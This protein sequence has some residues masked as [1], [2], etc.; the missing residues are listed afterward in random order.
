[1]RKLRSVTFAVLLTVFGTS[2]CKNSVADQNNNSP[3]SPTQQKGPKITKVAKDPGDATG[4]KLVITGTGFGAAQG[5]GKLTFNG[6]EVSAA[7]WGENK[8]TASVPPTI[9][10]DKI[11]II[12]RVASNKSYTYNFSSKAPA[13]PKPSCSQGPLELEL[14]A[15]GDSQGLANLLN[16]LFRDVKVDPGSAAGAGTSSKADGSLCVKDRATGRYLSKCNPGAGAGSTDAA[17]CQIQKIVTKV[18]IDAFKGN[19]LTSNFIVHLPILDTVPSPP[20]SIAKGLKGYFVRPAPNLEI[21]ELVQDYFL[22]A[23]ASGAAEQAAKIGEDLSAQ[24]GLVKRDLEQLDHLYGDAVSDSDLRQS[25]LCDMN[26]GCPAGRAQVADKAPFDAERW[27]AKHTVRLS[28]LKP[29]D[30]ALALQDLSMWTFQ[31]R[32]FGDALSILPAELSAPVSN[33][34]YFSADV[35]ERDMLY[36]QKQDEEK[37]TSSPKSTDTGGK[38]STPAPATTTTQ[39][40]TTLETISGGKATAPAL[41]TKVTT[42]TTTPASNPPPSSAP[43]CATAP[44]KPSTS[45]SD[46]TTGSSTVNATSAQSAGTDSSTKAADSSTNPG[47]GGTKGGGSTPPAAPAAPSQQPFRLD[48]VVRL[49]HLRQ[50][51]KIVAAI[52]AAASS[53]DKPLVQAVDDNGNNDLIL[54][55]PT[56]AGGADQTSSIR[57]AISMFDLPRPQLSLQVWSYQMSAQKKPLN[58][59]NENHAAQG[60]EVISTGLQET[61]NASND[62][63]MGALEAGYGTLLNLANN[64]AYF[65]QRFKNYLTQRFSN[66]ISENSYCL[67]YYDALDTSGAGGPAA[68]ASLNRLLLYLI[69]ASDAQ[70]PSAARRIICSMNNNVGNELC[71]AADEILQGA[72]CQQLNGTSQLNFTHFCEQLIKLGNPRNLHIFQAALLDFL[73]Q[74]RWTVVYP[75]DFV[76]YDLQRTAHQLDSLFGPIVDAFNQD[77]DRYI[78]GSLKRFTDEIAPT[79]S[80]KKTG[81]ISA[82]SVQVS[83]LSGTQATVDGKVNNYFD[84]TP[85]LS[86]NDI[87]NTGNQ[88]NLASNLKNILEPKEILILQSLANIGNQPRIT[89]EIS[90]EAKL[91]ITPTTLD[92]ASSALLDVDFDVSEPNGP[93]TVNQQNS[94]KDLLDR[95]AEHHVVTHVRVESLKLFQL[96]S[97]SMELTHPLR[98]TPVPVIGWAWESIFGTTPGLG[99]LFRMPPYSKTVDNRSYAIVRAVVVPTAMDLGLSL[100]FE[101]DRVWDPITRATDPLNSMKQA[102]GRLRPYHK[103]LMQC[104]VRGTNPCPATL[105]TTPE[106]LRDPSSP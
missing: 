14:L 84:I 27:L 72:S 45:G 103:Y 15:P 30:A 8:I 1:M 63:M 94:E 7:E 35:I 88:Q 95:V 13:T 22:L 62:K 92:T 43:A 78:A 66:C 9:S 52:N 18:D 83:S 71:A 106:D 39:S 25:M 47:S 79:L 44:Q 54:I 32:S 93:Q 90:K 97:F 40:T 48:N 101:G 74:Y 37:A 86:L 77:L 105:S 34:A 55:L 41:T 17:Y 80:G 61:V 75:D 73:F 12:V 10:L 28:I 4:R 102:G 11:T 42:V 58:I 85:P 3:A 57:R 29:R 89:A 21:Q 81:L 49:F 53:K 82:G 76:P 20:N 104:I 69:A 6:T 87:L 64:P 2:F 65:D 51:D 33:P 70:A 56:P 5:P 96:S 91:T 67:G 59:D 68:N 26:L 50:A 23:P 31:V 19:K 36:H 24:A 98:G 60:M 100:R 38:S 99:R 16:T 46:P